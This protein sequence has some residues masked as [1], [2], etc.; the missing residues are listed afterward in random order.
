MR[1]II[2][3]AAFLVSF[4]IGKAIENGK[5]LEQAKESEAQ[6]IEQ[7]QRPSDAQEGNSNEPVAWVLPSLGTL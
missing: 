7:V 3:V 2:T 4:T 6:R 1:A 5:A